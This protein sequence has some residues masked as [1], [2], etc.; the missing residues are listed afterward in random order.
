MIISTPAF[1]AKFFKSTLLL[2]G[3]TV[4]FLGITRST[5]AEEKVTNSAEKEEVSEADVTPKDCKGRCN[6]NK[7]QCNTFCEDSYE[8]A[9]EVDA[10]A[11]ECDFAFDDY[12]AE[13]C[14]TDEQFNFS[15][16]EEE[17]TDDID[18][19][20]A[21][22]ESHYAIIALNCHEKFKDVKDKQQECFNQASAFVNDT[23]FCYQ[24]CKVEP[25]FAC[26]PN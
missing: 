11:S 2:L 1:L 10:C 4:I 15:C 17:T 26:E 12:C 5:L 25:G 16:S 22:C 3:L 13:S 23:K 20:Q 7:K 21:A 8:S 18:A 14:K 9:D 19:C 24:L 6:L